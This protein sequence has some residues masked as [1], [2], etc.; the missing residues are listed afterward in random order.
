[1]PETRQL[2][3][4]LTLVAAQLVVMLDSSILNVALPSIAND[5]GLSATG[6]AWVLNAYFLTFGGLLLIS[7]R[8]AD[9]L[10]RRR[11]FLVG[12]TVLG[13]GSVLGAFSSS[14][15]ALITARLVQGAGAAMLSPAAM[16]AILARFT[17]S[18]RARTM[19]WWG[20]ASTIGGAAGV[21]VGGILT[22]GFGWHSVMT[23]TAGVAAAIG[24][25][26]WWTL[27]AD[28]KGAK[29]KFDGTG[30]SLL[31]TAAVALV[32][33]V[34]AVPQAGLASAEVLTAAGIGLT[35]VIGFVVVE[36]RNPDPLLPPAALREG[37]VAGGIIVNMLGGAARIACFALV[38]LLIQQVLL[39]DPAAAGLAM[40]PTSLAGFAVSALLLPRVL[41]RLGPEKATVAGLGLLVLTHVLF[42]TIDTGAPYSWRVLPVLVLAATGVAFSFTPTTLVIADGMAARNAGVSSGLASATAQ[43]GGAIGIAVFGAADAATRAATIRVGATPLEAANA[44][45]SVAHLAAACFALAAA[46]IALL[47]FPTLRALVPTR[48][49]STPL[50]TG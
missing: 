23:V 6:T 16:S 39:Y 13:L 41:K 48:P 35:A 36:R 1:M 11:M 46:I 28:P 32:A 5:L 45:L 12:A 49:A 38:A 17:G 43:I 18:A 7:G 31:T 21:T 50:P 24:V 22:G 33:A 19:S 2:P 14:E 34:L 26:A 10:G 37:R 29:R 9:V 15:T 44:G 8:A 30:A 3:L 20:A 40:L 25:I 4:V 47:T 27:P 42:A